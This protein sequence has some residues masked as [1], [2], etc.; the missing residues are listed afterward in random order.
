MQVFVTGAGG[1][2]GRNLLPRLLADGHRATVLLLPEEDEAGLAGCPVVRGD[3]TRPE[4]LEGLFE[5]CDA[6]VHLAAAVGYGQTLERCRRINRDGT[7][8][9]V[10]AAVAAD[11]R[12]FVQLSS[13]SVYGRRPGVPVGEDTPLRKTGDPYGD[14]KIEAEELLLEYARRGEID[15]TILRPTVIYGPG[16]DKFLPKLVE[17]LRSGRA[18]IIGSGENRV[19]AVHVEDV[20][21][22]IARV[23]ADE[24]AVGGVYNVNNPGNPSWNEL[25]ECVADALG[26][27]PPRSHLPYPIALAAAGAME[28]AA[29]LTGGEPRLTRYAVR[30]IGR[31]YDYRVDRAK[32]ELG[33]EAKID[34][35]EGVRRECAGSA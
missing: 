11:L 2:I 27:A 6:V 16:D 10:A 13:V 5:G 23:L 18:R 1:F 17:N 8:N 9:V 25:L 34:L 3:I 30:V 33:F 22:L 21:E 19:D 26:V 31:E 12:R 7:G 4:S 20:A 32:R 28:L 35:R 24:R 29:R 14:T 15:L